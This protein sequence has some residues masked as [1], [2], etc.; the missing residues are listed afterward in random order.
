MTSP[1]AVGLAPSSS[2]ARE[3]R[4][5]GLRGYFLCEQKVPKKSLRKLRFLRTFLITGDIVFFAR[6]TDFRSKLT[7]I[8][9]LV[10]RVYFSVVIGSPY[11]LGPSKLPGVLNESLLRFTALLAMAVSQI[12]KRR[13]SKHFRKD[14]G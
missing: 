13:R 8:R 3:L 5:P 9:L 6:G 2:I 12:K 11:R 10:F 14:R 7:A 1:R 4:A